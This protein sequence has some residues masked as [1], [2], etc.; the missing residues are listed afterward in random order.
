MVS[1]ACKGIFLVE[2]SLFLGVEDGILDLL[3]VRAESGAVYAVGASKELGIFG[4]DLDIL[5]ARFLPS[6]RHQLHLLWEFYKV[7]SIICLSIYLR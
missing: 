3:A 1:S 7:W 5:P 6:A 4:V 2:L